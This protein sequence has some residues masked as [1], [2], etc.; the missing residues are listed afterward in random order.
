MLAMRD[1]QRAAVEA[2][3]REFGRG[4]TRQLIVLPTG[5]GK[6][7]VF[8]HVARRRG[9]RTLVLAHRTELLDQ[10]AAKIQ[11][12]WPEA[13]VGRIQG[14]HD[15]H[16]GR[17]V[18]V[19]S[20]PTLARPERLERLA[21]EFATIIV[22]EAHHAVA[23]SYRRILDALAGGRRDVL[24]LGATA[25]P[26]RADGK[27]LRPVFEK[28]VYQR[29]LVH[30]IAA[31]YLCDLRAKRIYSRVSLDG[32]RVRAGD[33]DAAQ[34]ASVLNTANRN[35]LIVDSYL[36]FGE[37]RKAIL[38]AADIEHAEALADLFRR[39]GIPSQ[40]ISQ[41]TPARRRRA[42][43][44]AFRHGQIQVLTNV[45]VFTEGFDEPSI[46]CVILARPTRS[47]ALLAQMVG[48]GTR[49]CPGKR[50]CLVLDIAD[51]T[52]QHPLS[53]V[54]DLVGLEGAGEAMAAGRS[55]LDVVRQRQG[56]RQE[57]E[58]QVL[59]IGVDLQAF[60]V[61]LFHRSAFRWVVDGDRMRLPLGGGA[62]INLIPAGEDRWEVWL[63]SRDGAPV[64]LHE[65]ALPVDW[66]Q[67]V[68]EEYVRARAAHLARKDARWRQMEATAGQIA[69]LQKLGLP[70]RPGMT[71]GEASDAISQ[72]LD[73]RALRRFR[74]PASPRPA[75]G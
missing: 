44:Y 9:G 63:D 57:P 43:L 12:V 48:R 61:D 26:D 38:F 58:Q 71:R 52:A 8:S 14:P 75:A 65:R 68:A 69:A 19:A 34:L 42:L 39:R 73:V 3:E 15:R 59:G 33:F 45:A 66:A 11:L 2:V 50:D 30:M 74:R 53:T 31:G 20:V 35:E 72:L 28:I 54:A 47:R 4:V 49:L 17:D 41:R 10:A 24:V 64:R 36:R 13:R 25:T 32:V 70:V 1:Y 5:T 7:V 67:A 18:V 16:R 40:A 62:G 21:P 60:D 37:G 51:T 29:T 6:T 56:R 27:S 23:E 46:A 22:D 55:V